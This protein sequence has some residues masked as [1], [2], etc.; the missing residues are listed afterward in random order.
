MEHPLL[1]VIFRQLSGS[2]PPLRPRLLIDTLRLVERAA[3]LCDCDGRDR[4]GQARAHKRS[5]ALSLLLRVVVVGTDDCSALIQQAVSAQTTATTQQ[6][7]VSKAVAQVLQ[8]DGGKGNILG[9]GFRFR[10][11]GTNNGLTS[12]ASIENYFPNSVVTHVTRP[13]WRKLLAVIGGCLS[14]LLC[15]SGV[16]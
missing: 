9:L 8:V 5:C 15:C 10:R 1:A 12:C 13:E 4:V 7:V 3:E 16:S 14:G 6:A 2:G 11:Q